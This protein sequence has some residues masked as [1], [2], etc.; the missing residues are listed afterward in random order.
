MTKKK[1]LLEKLVN[2]SKPQPKKKPNYR[3]DVLSFIRKN[4][5]ATTMQVAN[6][7]ADKHSFLNSSRGRK[8]TAALRTLEALREDG[9][10]SRRRA[11]TS[12]NRKGATWTVAA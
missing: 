2:G 3:A 12:E 5:K 9:R 10:V 1:T 7:L 6:A 4:P 8:Y 11:R